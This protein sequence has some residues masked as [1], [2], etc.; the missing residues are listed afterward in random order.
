[1][2]A[3]PA[4]SSRPIDFATAVYRGLGRSSACAEGF[5][6][7]KSRANVDYGMAWMP[8]P[9]GFW[10]SPFFLAPLRPKHSQVSG[11]RAHLQLAN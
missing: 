3:M 1:M 10:L 9:T 8:S 11:M 4:W 7:L 2:T 5:A 6:T